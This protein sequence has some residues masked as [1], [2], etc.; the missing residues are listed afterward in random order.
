[1]IYAEKL[2]KPGGKILEK[3]IFINLDELLAADKTARE[4]GQC[5]SGSLE[6]NIA[7]NRYRQN[8]CVYC[9]AGIGQQHRNCIPGMIN[10]LP[11]N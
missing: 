7:L 6:T 1:M 8:T 4:A 11:R 10:R 9:G 3:G 5:F 2:E